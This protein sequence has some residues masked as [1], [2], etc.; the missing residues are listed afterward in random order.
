MTDL[1]Q[2]LVKYLTDVH[3]IE[4]Q[5]LAQMRVAPALASDPHLAEAFSA[6]CEETLDHERSIRELLVAHDAKPAVIKDLLGTLT[7]KGF[8]A[9]ARVQPDTPGK[10]TAHAFSYEHMEL[11]A[12]VM[13]GRVAT[14]AGDEASAAASRHICAQ[15][16][17]M[18]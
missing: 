15:E 7:G 8:A 16:Q 11:A 17:A 12:Y 9:F 5:A 2:Q 3:A 13:L 10:L 14:L 1:E 6:H 18:G 4:Q